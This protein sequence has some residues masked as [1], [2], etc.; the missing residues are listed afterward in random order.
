MKPRDIGLLGGLL[1]VLAGVAIIAVSTGAFHIPVAHVIDA[2]LQPAGLSIGSR[3]TTEQAA[4][5][6]S[7]RLPRTAMGLLMGAGL[8]VAGAILQSLFRNPLADPGLVGVTSGA[9]LA[10]AAVIVLSSTVFAGLARSLGLF[11]LPLA[12][13][14]GSAAVILLIYRLS[15]HGGVT[16]LPMMLL[17]GIALS[18]VAG[19]GVGLFIFIAT[20]DQLRTLMFWTL[21]SLAPSTWS[22]LT[23]TTPV[24]LACVAIAHWHAPQLNALLLG[25]AEAAHIG[26]DVQR[27]KRMMIVL[28]ALTVG[29]LVAFCGPV[30]FIGLV[31]PH[32]VRLLSGPDHRVVLPGCALLGAALT[33]AAD[34][35]ARTAFAPTEIP[36]G[37]LTALLGAPFFLFLLLR[38]R[39]TWGL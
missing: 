30:G 12:A 1:I 18:S 21:G 11:T 19:A 37:I 7:I 15:T 22:V 27:L 34:L 38:E 20:D 23:I 26:V 9:A 2:L 28:C 4:V 5:L 24:V 32:C 25:E 35:I 13:F 17:A 39:R 16:L 14:G 10:A 31:A 33:A 36:L 6:W 3:L 29:V 8:A